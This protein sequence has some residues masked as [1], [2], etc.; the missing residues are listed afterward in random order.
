MPCSG[1]GPYAPTLFGANHMIGGSV[2][3]TAASREESIMAGFI[4]GALFVGGIVV[5]AR[6]LRRR[7]RQGHWDKEGHGSPEHPEPGVKF[8]PLESPPRE[9]FD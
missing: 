1:F 9:P 5:L 6:V 4:L 3:W 8:R 2:R 7:E